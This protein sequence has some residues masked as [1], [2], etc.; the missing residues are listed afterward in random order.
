MEVQ[1]VNLVL[2]VHGCNSLVGGL[3]HLPLVLKVGWGFPVGDRV[4]N[5]Q[6][7][8][9]SEIIVYIFNDYKRAAV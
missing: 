4:R 9:C 3:H 2:L 5:I 6:R 1:V 7:T 8:E